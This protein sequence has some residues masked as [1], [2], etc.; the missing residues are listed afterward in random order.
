MIDSFGKKQI[1]VHLLKFFFYVC[2]FLKISIS[3]LSSSMLSKNSV[4]LYGLAGWWVGFY[5][6]SDLDSFYADD[7]FVLFVHGL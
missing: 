4:G 7:V 1:K 5:S 2:I 3:P 6:M